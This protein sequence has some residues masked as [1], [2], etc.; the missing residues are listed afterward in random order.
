MSDK[1]EH[2]QTTVRPPD[3]ETALAPQGAPQGV[4]NDFLV[5]LAKDPNIT[6]EKLAQFIAIRNHEE[7]RQ[8]KRTYNEAMAHFAADAPTITK[9]KHN[10]QYDSYYASIEALVTPT[11]P[12]LSKHGFS[13]RWEYPEGKEGQ[14]GVSCILT[15]QDGHSERVTRF[16]PPDTSGAKNPIQQIKSTTTYLQIITFQAVT[17]LVAYGHLNDDGNAA[18]GDRITEEQQVHLA[19]RLDGVNANMPVFLDSFGI[20]ELGQ[21]TVKDYDRAIHMVEAKEARQ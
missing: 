3:H 7:D 14:I 21:L 12:V 16:A 17:G 19:L 11:A 10:K 1:V 6:P 2:V 13:H 15:H 8:A 5:K 18:G 20:T 9:D 4:S